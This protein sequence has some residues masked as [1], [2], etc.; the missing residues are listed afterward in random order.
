MFSCSETAALVHSPQ[1][2]FLS[3]YLLVQCVLCVQVF[4]AQCCR[5]SGMLML[6]L[7]S[8]NA[9]QQQ[10]TPASSPTPVAASSSRKRRRHH[11]SRVRL[12]AS[13]PKRKKGVF[14]ETTAV[15]TTASQWLTT[16][17]TF[18]RIPYFGTSFR[19]E[20]LGSFVLFVSLLQML[21]CVT[22][23]LCRLLACLT[24]KAAVS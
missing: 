6:F 1:L 16:L 20:Y 3:V 19:Y 15:P 8:A 18:S 21:L 7:C 9:G 2:E 17:T 14:S 5:T 24:S 22:S 4:T 11:R 13:P 12:S 10:P 23:S